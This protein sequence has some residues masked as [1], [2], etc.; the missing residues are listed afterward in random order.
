L[1][2]LKG[3]EMTVRDQ[4]V[5]DRNDRIFSRLK[6]MGIFSVSSLLDRM[7]DA[8]LTDSEQQAMHLML[9]LGGDVPMTLKETGARM[10]GRTPER[11]RQ[12]NLKALRKLKRLNGTA[13]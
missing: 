2:W 13:K 10:G 4:A 3:S 5:N 11:V 8:G 12:I 7:R 1:S 9:G 6:K